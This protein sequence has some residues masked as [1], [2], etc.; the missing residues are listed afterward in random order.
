MAGASSMDA[1]FTVGP[2]FCG[3]DRSEN[4]GAAAS[5]FAVKTAIPSTMTARRMQVALA[6]APCFP[7]RLSQFAFPCVPLRADEHVVE[8]MRPM[9]P[10]FAVLGRKSYMVAEYARATVMSSRRALPRRCCPNCAALLDRSGLI[11]ACASRAKLG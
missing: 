8:P 4:L 6:I 2:R 10:P 1:E 7:I 9:K 11:S 5:G 3:A